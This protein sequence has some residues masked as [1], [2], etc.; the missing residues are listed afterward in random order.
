MAPALFEDPTF[1]SLI[2]ALGG[3]RIL[4]TITTLLAL[5]GIATGHKVLSELRTAQGLRHGRKLAL[6]GLVIRYLF[7]PFCALIV[8]VSVS[9]NA[10]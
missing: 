6:V 8:Y 2:Y 4:F 10:L 1:M 5:V 3:E 7:L 9:M